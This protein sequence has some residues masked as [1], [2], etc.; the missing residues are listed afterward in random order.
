M[1]RGAVIGIVVAA[2]VVVAGGAVAAWALTR[3]AGP[4]D[5]A[6]SYLTALEEGDAAAALARTDVEKDAASRAR[7]AYDGAAARLEDTRVAGTREDGDTAQVE[8]A[9]TLDGQDVEATLELR[10]RDGA[11]RIENGLGSVRPQATLGDAVTVGEVVVPV[12]GEPL[13]LLPA[14]YDVAAA[15]AEVLT[16]STTVDVTAGADIPA[17]VEASLSPDATGV[18]QVQLDAY[19]QQCARPATTVP[20]N[21]GL[22]IPWGADLSALSSLDFRIEKTPQVAVSADATSFDATGGVIV[23]TARGTSR[24]GGDGVFTYRA[25]DW[26]LRGAVSFDGAQLVLSVR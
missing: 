22:K 26:A 2:A 4:S 10:R 8:V 5:V 13:A 15:P 23:A 19:A 14:R 25:D 6:L 11:W 12:G 9:Y 20:P 1:K 3:P 16:G 7:A 17:A 21:C 24:G 18:I